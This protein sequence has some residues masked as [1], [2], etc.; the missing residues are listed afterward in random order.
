M[1]GDGTVR[2]VAGRLPRA[3]AQPSARH[4]RTRLITSAA[5]AL[6]VVAV[7]QV[8]S[9]L[10]VL[11]QRDDLS[12]ALVAMDP[13][14]IKDF[15]PTLAAGTIACWPPLAVGLGG[16]ARWVATGSRSAAAAMW[17]AGLAAILFAG[18]AIVVLNLPLDPGP[19]ERQ[20]FARHLPLAYPV[21][22][23]AGGLSIG[24]YLLALALRLAA[25]VRRTD[26]TAK[27][28]R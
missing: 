27:A 14:G 7:L 13:S 25:A 20:I 3:D 17:L 5:V 6:A 24:L 26:R 23:L 10:T 1:D 21:L 19:G 8:G 18:L 2:V 9:A 22:V 11:A 4:R 12:R 15:A 28:G 16:I